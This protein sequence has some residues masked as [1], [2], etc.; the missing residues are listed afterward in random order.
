MHYDRWADALAKFWLHDTNHE[1]MVLALEPALLV[2]VVASIGE[3][4]ATE[5]EAEADFIDAVRSYQAS[6]GLNPWRTAEIINGK[7]RFL[8]LI[9][10][11]VYAASQMDSD[12][13]RGH[14]PNAYYVQLEK[15]VGERA[16]SA[17][18]AA[19]HGDSHRALWRAMR[20]WATNNGRTIELPSD[21]VGTHERN[22]G[23]PKSQALLRLADLAE[24]PLFFRKCGYLPSQQIDLERIATKVRQYRD[25]PNVFPSRWARRVLEDSIRFTAACRQ[26]RSELSNWDG[27]WEIADAGRRIPK[28][29][30]R[31]KIWFGINHRKG[32]LLAKYGND[33]DAAKI[34]PV[35]QLAGLLASQSIGGYQLQLNNGLCVCRFEQDDMAFKQVASVQPGDRCL[36]AASN[37]VSGA[38]DLL[39]MLASCQLIAKSPQ[40]YASDANDDDEANALDGIPEDCRV[41]VMEIADPLPYHDYVDLVW[42]RFLRSPR[43][44]LAPLGGLRFGRIARWVAGAGPSIRI[45]GN[46]LPKSISI[47]GVTTTVEGRIVTNW[48]LSEPGDHQ[49]LA[50]IDG[51][52]CECSISVSDATEPEQPVQVENAWAFKSGPPDWSKVDD[53]IS[54]LFGLQL[55]RSSGE[56]VRSPNEDRR[57]AI[58]KLAGFPDNKHLTSLGN[59]NHPLTRWLVRGS[60]S[61]AN[62]T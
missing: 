7:A 10:A 62:E 60:A 38:F 16:M 58:A 22:V 28:N 30:A 51:I 23:L 31:G 19:D 25:D 17:N 3:A 46:R 27:S 42:H 49:V 26:I 59:Y 13:E 15:L 12:E 41:V 44:Q 18:F 45:V 56:Q 54:W 53:D 20:K 11:Q 55:H 47:N 8:L 14:G 36:L 21:E 40:Y 4:F 29:N 24:L 48:R 9:A 61:K 37:K 52:A 39:R 34:L 50:T 43:P 33:I 35:E 1:E 2:D 32:S 5:G 6:L 57:L